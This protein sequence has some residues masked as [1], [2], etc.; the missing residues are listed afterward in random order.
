MK[1][2]LAFLIAAPILA[3]A[4]GFAFGWGIG[5]FLKWV[6][7]LNDAGVIFVAGLFAFMGVASVGYRS[8]TVFKLLYSGKRRPNKKGLLGQAFRD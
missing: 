4:S 2:Y 8:W 3:G 5:L 6:S 7:D 1:A